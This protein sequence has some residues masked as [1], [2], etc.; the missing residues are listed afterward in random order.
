MS[1][2]KFSPAPLKVFESLA[3]N[4]IGPIATWPSNSYHIA[5]KAMRRLSTPVE[6]ICKFIEPCVLLIILYCSS[7]TFPGLL[8]HKLTLLK[9]SLKLISHVCG[10]GFRYLAN[11]VYE[12]HIKTSSDFAARILWGQ[13][14]LLHEELSKARSHTA[15]R[16]RFKRL[17]SMTAAY[18]NS[19]LPVLSGILVD[20][21]VELKCYIQELPWRTS[22]SP[23]PY[24]ITFLA[25]TI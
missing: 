21:N 10:L 9:R 11:L 24:C 19:V 4:S 15:T 6:F 25:S 3:F 7:A 22:S 20:L 16:S 23:F 1:P 18:R 12:R 2:A 14:H 17:P 5:Y 13:Q 8:K